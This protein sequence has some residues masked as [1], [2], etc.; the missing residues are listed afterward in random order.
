ML[1]TDDLPAI[2]KTFADS[3]APGGGWCDELAYL[4]SSKLSNAAEG[5]HGEQYQLK[6]GDLVGAAVFATGGSYPD[7]ASMLTAI[8]EAVAECTADA[9]N[10]DYGEATSEPLTGLPDGAVG[11]TFTS[12]SSNPRETGKTAYVETAD[13]NLLAVGVTHYGDGEPSVDI[14]SLLSTALERAPDVDAKS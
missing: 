12:S 13:G 11:F 8:D 5:T 6:N 3:G 7:A 14:T 10:G 4:E 9:A 1:D 2:E